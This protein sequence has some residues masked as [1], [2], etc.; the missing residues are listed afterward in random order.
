[1]TAPYETGCLTELRVATGPF[2]M[3]TPRGFLAD[4]GAHAV[5]VF[6]AALTPARL[7]KMA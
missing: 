6:A 2:E 1:M 4:E 3:L 7:H 5:R